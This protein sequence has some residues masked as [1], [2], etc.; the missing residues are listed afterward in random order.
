MGR[1]FLNKKENKMSDKVYPIQISYK[2][3]TWDYTDGQ[4][5]GLRSCSV[6]VSNEVDTRVESDEDNMEP[7]E[8]PI[9]DGEYTEDHIN[10][11]LEYYSK[12]DWKPAMY[13]QVVSKYGVEEMNNIYKVAVYLQMNNL[14]TLALIRLA[15]EVY[16]SADDIDA[17]G[18]LQEK[19]NIQEP[20]NL[21]L[22]NEMLKKYAFIKAD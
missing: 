5:A 9:A 12:N 15:V 18:K 3:K 19:L 22:Q 17:V 7:I 11:C 21:D 6:L 4:A 20:F 8:V 2:G 13:G 10:D 14:Q 16:C 1:Y